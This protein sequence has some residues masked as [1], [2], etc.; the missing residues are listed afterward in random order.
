MEAFLDVVKRQNITI[1][2]YKSVISAS[3]I[4]VLGYL[5][6]DGKIRPDPERLRPLKERPLPTDVQGLR[7][8][9]WLFAYYAKWI[10]EFLS[11]IQSLVKA[12]ECP[13]P[14][15]AENAFNVMKNDLEVAS[16]NPTDDVMPFVVE[17]DAS[18]SRIYATLNHAGRPV[19]FMSRTL[20]DS[21]LHYPDS[22]L[23]YPDHRSCPKV[24]RLPITPRVS[25]DH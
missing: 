24:V 5:V 23:H 3:S 17:C 8:T 11:K 21:E 16:L 7:R 4:N 19:A 22:E 12:K 2:H 18:E 13:L 25:S 9:L 1:N 6:E 20:Q 10:P 15:L 14:T